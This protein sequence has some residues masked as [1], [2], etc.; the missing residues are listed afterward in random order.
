MLIP[1]EKPYETG[2]ADVLGCIFGFYSMEEFF[3]EDK[4]L[5]YSEIM[6]LPLLRDRS[7]GKSY[8]SPIT[9]DYQM[10]ILPDSP[11]K[12]SKLVEDTV[13]NWKSTTGIELYQHELFSK[14]A[15][16]LNETLDVNRCLSAR[17]PKMSYTRKDRAVMVPPDTP[18]FRHLGEEIR[19][20]RLDTVSCLSTVN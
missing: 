3:F 6:L 13:K 19:K 2:D 9:L 11:M 16:L 12:L 17:P 15:Y 14:I 4:K 1:F 8:F 7:S 18:T 5:R 10:N 20:C